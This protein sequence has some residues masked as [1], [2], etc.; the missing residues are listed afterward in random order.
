M[1]SLPLGAVAEG[2]AAAAVALVPSRV[3]PSHFPISRVLVK[4]L[5][6]VLRRF[7]G[8]ALRILDIAFSPRAH[9]RQVLL[10]CAVQLLGALVRKARQLLAQ[11]TLLG[12]PA[13]A[14][15]R[16]YAEWRAAED[17]CDVREGGGAL[18][19]LADASFFLTL[20]DK[21]A[22]YRR[23]LA[24]GDE[25]GLMYHLRAE[26]MRGHGG[27]SG[28]N[29]DG[30]TWL[31][32]HRAARAR[33]DAYQAD[34]CA[35]L[36]FV[37]EGRAPHSLGA[38]GRLAFINETRHAYGRTA[39]MLSGGAA[40]GVKHL[41][42][43]AALH[44]ERLLPRIVCGTSA[45]SI[46]AS[47]ICVKTDEE[48][49]ELLLEKR[50]VGLITS[51]T[52]FG[53]KRSDTSA[54]EL[55]AGEAEGGA[56]MWD[57]RRGTR[58]ISRKAALLD[59]T[60]LE[61]TLRELCGDLTFL[62]AFDRTGRVLNVT[63]TRSDGRAPAM[64]CNYITTPHLLV[65]SASLASC[66]I[67]G[68]FEPVKLMAKDRDG[69]VVP[70]F[71]IGNYKW[72]DGGLQSDLP[73]QR[74]TE[75]FNVNQF[76][77]SQVNPLA[78]LFVPVQSGLS[79]L[80]QTFW[81]LKHQLVGWCRGVSLLADG[82]FARPFGIRA[83]DLA[84]QEY[85]GTVTIFPAWELREMA[86][87]LSNFDTARAEQYMMDGERATWLHLPVIRSLCEVE[88]TLDEVAADLQRA[89]AA[90]PHSSHGKLPSY[91]S[92]AAYGNAAAQPEGSGEQQQAYGGL[93]VASN[94]SMLNLAAMG[95]GGEGASSM[96]R[97]P[98][99]GFA[100]IPMS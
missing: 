92:L 77:V 78:P 7:P 40:F 11:Y 76:I 42:V 23:L 8:F 37:G 26:L 99:V 65:C 52:F 81:L 6:R 95:M 14:N 50:G 60:V 98:S 28:Y 46:V 89:R 97:T 36:R 66:T 62:E 1:A 75:L 25:Y 2:A 45:G 58:Q 70:Y 63:V 38:A 91:I 79:M 88:F 74:L 30:S 29:R 86:Q 4:L 24:A 93:R 43:A 5:R 59:S 96:H 34:V 94:A 85:E 39:L 53:L 69:K 54:L 21:A 83:V 13:P 56:V 35:A 41:G 73:K 67:P 17:E 16:S 90:A 80:D 100:P 87:F 57:L 18:P 15:C 33:I 32:K 71:R 9:V 72:T 22:N 64:L 49:D 19:T 47:F 82:R 12:G 3:R 61:H 44:R 68:V 51:L 20:S 55:P 31:R 84:M 48:L 27:G 10:A